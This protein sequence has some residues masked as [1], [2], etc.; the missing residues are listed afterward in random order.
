MC[1]HYFDRCFQL[2]ILAYDVYTFLISINRP[3]FS[4][5]TNCEIKRFMPIIFIALSLRKTIHVL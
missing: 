4:H 1:M 3:M 2:E 5:I